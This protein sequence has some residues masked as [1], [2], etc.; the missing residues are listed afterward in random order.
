MRRSVAAGNRI[1]EKNGSLSRSFSVSRLG[2]GMR[3]MG[4]D[5]ET[6]ADIRVCLERKRNFSALG[7]DC[8]DQLECEPVLVSVRRG[9]LGHRYPIAGNE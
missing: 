5:R 4:I 1:N 2:G 9:V 3:S 7:N 6:A 8:G